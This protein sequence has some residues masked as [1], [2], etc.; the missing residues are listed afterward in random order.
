[1]Q[2]I[3]RPDGRDMSV[4]DIPFNWDARLDIKKLRVGYIKESFDTLSNATAKQNAAKVLDTLR[5]LGVSDFV[6]MTIPS[7]NTSGSALGVESAAFFDHMTRAGKMKG[8]RGGTRASSWLTRR[9][10]SSS[11]SAC[12]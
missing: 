2:A 10:S 5:S 7:P 1:M 9:W 3:A 11:N 6:P 4:S 12:A 8:A